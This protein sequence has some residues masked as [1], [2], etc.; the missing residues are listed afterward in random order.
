[1]PSMGVPTP[2]S[3]PLT[4]L[5]SYSFTISLS[6]PLLSLSYTKSRY[7]TPTLAIP[8]SHSL[9]NSPSHYLAISTSTLTIP[10]SLPSHPLIVK[11]NRHEC[12]DNISIN[13]PCGPPNLFLGLQHQKEVVFIASSDVCLSSLR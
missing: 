6:R 13:K 2:G 4:I 7:L 9:T 8:A 12:V 10:T 3:H 11:K 5:A 1:M